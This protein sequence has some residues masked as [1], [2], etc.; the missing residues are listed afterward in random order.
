MVNNVLLV[1]VE[2]IM[3]NYI[4]YRC[5]YEVPIFILI[6]SIPLLFLSAVFVVCKHSILKFFKKV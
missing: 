2:V 6:L 1:T 4:D 5:S 3:K